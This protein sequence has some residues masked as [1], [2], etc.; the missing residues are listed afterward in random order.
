M[1]RE[2]WTSRSIYHVGLDFVI[3]TGLGTISCTMKPM[4][5]A[6]QVL[7]AAQSLQDACIA[8]EM[9]KDIC[10]DIQKTAINRLPLVCELLRIGQ[11]FPEAEGA[12]DLNHK[13]LQCLTSVCEA[14]HEA[15]IAMYTYLQC[16]TASMLLKAASVEELMIEKRRQLKNRFDDVNAYV[17]MANLV[18]SQHGTEQAHHTDAEVRELRQQMRELQDV[19]MCSADPARVRALA[20]AVVARLSLKGQKV[21]VSEDYVNTVAVSPSGKTF[22]TGSHDET[23]AVWDIATGARLLELRGHRAA[24]LSVA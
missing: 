2:G 24:V 20:K 10:A 1:L 3:D 9:C 16:N 15:C 13:M 5:I 8:A 11:L 23:A 19:Y 6:G 22:A 4:E 14:L 17:N 21:K 12:A 18:R 7:K